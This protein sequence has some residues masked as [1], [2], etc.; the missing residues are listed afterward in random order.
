MFKKTIEAGSLSRIGAQVHNFMNGFVINDPTTPDLVS[1]A[2]IPAMGPL[3]YAVQGVSTNPKNLVERRA[4]NCHITLGD[5][6][7]AVQA[8]AK[9]PMQRWASTSLLSVLPAA[10]ADMNAYYDRRSLRFFYYNFRGKNTYF[11]DSAD[12]VT[13][14]LGHAILD[15]MRPDFWSVQALEIWSFHEAFSDIMAVFNLLN[16]EPVI[17]KV[18]A[19][20]GGNLR[21]SNSASRLAEQV[22]VLLRAVTNDPSY[23]PNALRDPAAEVY[24]Y[25]NPSTL[26]EDAPN[27]RLA[28]E[29]HSFGRV[30]SAAWYNAL[31]RVCDLMV[32]KGKDKASAIRAARD[33]CFKVLIYAVPTA[34]R[35]NNF[36]AAMAK[37][38]VASAKDFGPEYSK[39]FS[40]VFIEWG[41]I[42]DTPLKALSAT[43]YGEAIASLKKSD[44]MIKTKDG[45]AIMSM[46]RSMTAKLNEVPGVYD[47]SILN[48]LSTNNLEFEL[49]SDLYYEFDPSGRL[50]DEMFSDRKELLKSAS[51]C[52]RQALTDGMWG[53][54]NGR[55]VRKFIR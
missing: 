51:T 39:I 32:S 29:C 18:L 42:S 3:K 50:V 34:P 6:I 25:V 55:L 35:V 22:G 17:T 46:R 44:K 1:N 23:L 21:T 26:A 28:A 27:N 4:L 2:P 40:D 54:M 31:A 52:V 49:P 15:G 37:C 7:N 16:Y 53:E 47:G 41:I 5:C 36:Y 9:T 43:T 14:E 30:F 19:E 24:K 10:G 11:S 12:I 33:L 13:H 38:M 8:L 45:G 48:T 20:T